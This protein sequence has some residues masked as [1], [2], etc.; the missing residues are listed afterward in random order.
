[1][2]RAE[3]GPGSDTGDK[4][5]QLLIIFFWES[6]ESHWNSRTVILNK[7]Q[8]RWFPW[9]SPPSPSLGPQAAPGW[10]S[11]ADA[12]AHD[13]G[14][15]RSHHCIS[16]AGAGDTLQLQPAVYILTPEGTQGPRGFLMGLILAPQGA[17]I[18][19]RSRRPPTTDLRNIWK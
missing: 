12:T 5:S 15:S 7:S 2:C 3:R 11:A 14:A 18:M 13:E 6:S 8:D 9:G 16:T 1:M 4:W 17:S 10:S 19:W